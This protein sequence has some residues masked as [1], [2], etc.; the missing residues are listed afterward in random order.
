[1]YHSKHGVILNACEESRLKVK[2]AACPRTSRRSV[3]EGNTLGQLGLVGN[4][5]RGKPESQRR[6]KNVVEVPHEEV[7]NTGT[8]AGERER[9]SATAPAVCARELL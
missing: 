9:R 5:Q 6:L 4:F 1:M 7:A 2:R 8:D 3:S